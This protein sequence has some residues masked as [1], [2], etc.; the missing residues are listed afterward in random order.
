MHCIGILTPAGNQVHIWLGS[1]W[2]KHGCTIL[3]ATCMMDGWCLPHAP[4]CLTQPHRRLR[5][6]SWRVHT[7]AKLLYQSHTHA[8]TRSAALEWKK[9]ILKLCMLLSPLPEFSSLPSVIFF[10]ECFI[11]G[12]RQRALCR[13]PRK[14]PSVKENTQRR[15]SLPSVT[16]T[17]LGKELFAECFFSNTRQRQ[18]KNH[19]LK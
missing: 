4:P 5:S 18:F 15:S 8:H 14:K 1:V 19:I 7:A 16:N 6:L 12:T 3:R 17:T 9:Q 11:S 10:A 2:Q 13:V